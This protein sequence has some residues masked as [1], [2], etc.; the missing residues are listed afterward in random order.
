MEIADVEDLIV[1]FYCGSKNL[2]PHLK[3]TLYISFKHFNKGDFVLMRPHDPKLVLVWMGREHSML[4]MMMKIFF[5][6]VK[7]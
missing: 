2:K 1:V 6:M 5:R 4:S 7:V 3:T